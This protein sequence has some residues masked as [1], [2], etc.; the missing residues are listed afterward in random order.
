MQQYEQPTIIAE[1][2]FSRLRL[3]TFHAY[4]AAWSAVLSRLLLVGRSCRRTNGYGLG[5]LTLGLL[6]QLATFF[7]RL[8]LVHTF[9]SLSQPVGLAFDTPAG[10][11]GAKESDARNDSK[12]ET[13]ESTK[14]NKTKRN[15]LL[16][17]FFHNKKA[18]N[19]TK[20]PTK[21]TTRQ[22]ETRDRYT[23]IPTRESWRESKSAPASHFLRD[24]TTKHQQW[25]RNGFHEE[26]R[27]LSAFRFILEAGSSTNSS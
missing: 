10:G 5:A 8:G 1:R 6:D 7:V 14:R 17:C 4:S 11:V 22:N 9:V 20:H 18:R 16:L 25:Q 3:S 12:H 27:D 15:E 2:S 13:K 23:F 26:V 21:R 24:H 19:E